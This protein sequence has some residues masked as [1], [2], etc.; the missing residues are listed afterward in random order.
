M[1]NLERLQDLYGRMA[2]GQMME[3]F[4]QYYADD[5]TIV[6]AN[7]EVRQGKDAQ[8]KALHEWAASIKEMHGGGQGEAM[9]NEAA[10][11]TSI[12]SWMEATFQ[13][14]NRWKMEEIAV[15]KWEDGKIVHERFYYNMPGQ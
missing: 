12:E 11:T 8:R 3:V 1:T 2:Q 4:E 10:G 13:D 6:E 15:Q 5:V 14:G 9:S 7:G